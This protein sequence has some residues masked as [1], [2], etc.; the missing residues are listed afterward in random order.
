MREGVSKAVKK[1]IVKNTV[2]K[3]KAKPQAKAAAKEKQDKEAQN[4]TAPLGARSDDKPTGKG[5]GARPK[6]KPEPS[7]SVPK[8]QKNDDAKEVAPD[9]GQSKKPK[10]I[11][12]RAMAAG[13]KPDGMMRPAVKNSKRKNEEGHIVEIPIPVSKKRAK[14]PPSRRLRKA[15]RTFYE[16]LRR[17]LRP[18]RLL[19]R[20]GRNIFT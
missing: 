2:A 3:D 1:K 18:N 11:K 10:L 6:A 13:K 15:R 16:L 4:A 9:E 8:K 5:K 14:T 19:L 7:T 17:R 12:P 20:K